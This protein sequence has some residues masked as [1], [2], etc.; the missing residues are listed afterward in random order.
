MEFEEVLKNRHSC[1][2]FKMDP[3]GEENMEKIFVAAQMGPSAR[4][5]RPYRFVAVESEENRQR[6][7]DGLPF[8]RY[9]S[10]LIILIVGDERKS[11]NGLWQ[12]DCGAAAENI[13]LEATNL[14]LGSL[15]CAVYPYQ[16]RLRGVNE[17]A[18]VEE[19]EFVYCAILLGYEDGYKGREKVYDKEK[20]RRI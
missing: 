7:Y 10:P 3:I 6:V 17:V 4:N 11:A 15:W 19:G 8:G 16:D 20:V 14:G 1:R 12:A 9:P 5:L 18:E 13:L 2:K